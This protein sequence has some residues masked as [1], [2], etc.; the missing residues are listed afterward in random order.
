MT[1]RLTIVIP[2]Y[3]EA[4]NL[5]GLV[6]GVLELVPAAHVLIVDDNSPDG[7]GAIADDLAA[8]TGQVQ[9]LHRAQKDGIGPAYIAGFRLA[10]DQGA[11]LI[12]EMDADGSH[13]P[14]DLVRLLA[15]TKSADLVI[16]SRY[17]AGGE[18][19]G[20]PQSRKLLSRAGGMYARFVLRAP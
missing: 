15:A 18:T 19:V 10:L 9:V 1:E 13:A 17:I 11:D 6:Q 5:A 3:N 12:A 4:A 8:N 2:T 14:T 7:T 20:W 16:G